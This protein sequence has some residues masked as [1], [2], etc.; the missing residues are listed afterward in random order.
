MK[1]QIPTGL[2]FAVSGIPYW[3]MD[4][5]GFCVENRYARAKEGSEDMEEWRELNTRWFQ[6]GSFCPLFRSHGQYPL[7]EIYN[8]SPETHPAYKSM[9]YYDKL[10]YRLM[11]YIYSLAGMTHF[12]DYTIMR[13]L[14]MDFNG[15]PEIYN[16]SDQYMFGPSLLVAPVYKYKSRSREVYLPAS[17]GW[18]DFYSGKYLKGG[19]RFIADAPYEK[20]PLFVREGTILPVGPEIQ[21][22][23]EKK[24]DTLIIFVYTGKDCDFKLYEDEGSNYNYEKGSYSTILFSYNEAK[25]EVTIG[26]R[27][28]SFSGMLKTRTFKIVFISKEK[29]V[30]FN[31]EITPDVT[32]NYDGNE[33]KVIQQNQSGH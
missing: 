11:P 6:F 3:T 17:S 27:K 5:G 8:L 21:Y 1:A 26:E 2:N 24:P 7:R 15:D 9:V 32:T 25:R 29:M 18:Y 14:I 22:T 12:N 33:R 31:P 10:R 30:T 28:G 20:L 16:I 13:P 19:Q 4:I 23:S